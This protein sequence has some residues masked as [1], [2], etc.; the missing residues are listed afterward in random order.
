MQIRNLIGDF[1]DEWTKNMQD[2]PEQK[3]WSACIEKYIIAWKIV[4]IYL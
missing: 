3:N 2:L 1:D 4:L